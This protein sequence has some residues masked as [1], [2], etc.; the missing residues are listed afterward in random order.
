MIRVP[1][2]KEQQLAVKLELFVLHKNSGNTI[3]E[4]ALC[5][6][7]I[8]VNNW[9]QKGV[10]NGMNEVRNLPKVF[11]AGSQT[12]H[13]RLRC[14]RDIYKMAAWLLVCMFRP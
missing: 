5:D 9:N 8:S 10:T 4:R 14:S 11:R 13:K 3:L 6:N 12:C 1:H 7:L 2:I